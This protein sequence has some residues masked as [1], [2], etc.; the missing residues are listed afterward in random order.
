MNEEKNGSL[1][2]LCRTSARC[3]KH[4]QVGLTIQTCMRNEHSRLH[5]TLVLVQ[6]SAF[7]SEQVSHLYLH[8]NAC[9][10]TQ[11]LGN[12]GDM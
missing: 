10:C 4:E 6:M 5:C 3:K 9:T 11:A 7:C 8:T 12:H 1:H 2:S